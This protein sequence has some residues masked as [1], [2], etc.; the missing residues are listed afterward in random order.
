MGKIMRL[1]QLSFLLFMSGC[2]VVPM[3]A[4]IPSAVVEPIFGQ[5]GSEERSLPI[6]MRT[7]LVAVQRSLMDMKLSVDI[8]EIDEDGYNIG[9]GNDTLSGEI[10]LSGQ[11]EKLTTIDVQ[12]RTR[13]REESV[14]LAILDQ[15]E[16]RAKTIGARERFDFRTYHYLRKKPSLTSEKVGW[17]RPGAK[18]ELKKSRDADWLMIKLPSGKHAFLKGSIKKQT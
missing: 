15:I 9:F 2:A 13:T 18:L 12:V 3:L 1:L 4:A 5:F 8:L 6:S 17:Y 14:E 10:E 11:T 16:K 7:S